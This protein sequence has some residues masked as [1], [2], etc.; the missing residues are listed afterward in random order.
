MLKDY[1]PHKEPIRWSIQFGL[2]FGFT[3]ALVW[4]VIHYIQNQEFTWI[5]IISGIAS[6][7][8]VVGLGYFIRWYQKKELKRKL[9]KKSQ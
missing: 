3:Y 6:F 9:S 4:T 8:A 1:K 5:G 2:V 7:F